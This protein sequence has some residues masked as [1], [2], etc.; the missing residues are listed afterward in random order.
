[1]LK[2][3]ETRYRGAR[4]RS[5]T[6]ARWAVYFDSIGLT[7]E[8]EREGYDLGDGVLYLPDFW[9]PQVSMFA[10]VKPRELLPDEMDKIERLVK[11]GG[12]PCLLLV[13][14]PN[15]ALFPAV[16]W[17]D[18]TG[19]ISHSYALSMYHDYPRTE[20]RFYCDP[21]EYELY[22]GIGPHGAFW[23]VPLG[24]E[25]ARC[26][27]FE[28][29]ENGPVQIRDVVTSLEGRIGIALGAMYRRKESA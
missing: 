23:D 5:R 1:M 3:I 19:F 29:G 18:V 14:M 9:L 8:Y 17:D 28:F 21:A 10:E 12:F 26:A 24:V 16:E 20:G 13:G 22:D 7:W 11:Q 4:F 2:P 25:A 15:I 6:E 27:R